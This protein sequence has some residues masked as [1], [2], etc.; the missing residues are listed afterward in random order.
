MANAY[1]VDGMSI[2]Q[3]NIRDITDRRQAEIKLE[4]SEM[5]YRQMFESGHFGIFTTDDKFRFIS[6]NPTICKLLGYTQIELMKMKFSDITYPGTLERDIQ[7]AKDLHDGKISIY[8]S[9]KRYIK[10]NKDVIWV[11]ITVSAIRD[12]Y[13]KFLYFLVIVEDIDE[14][15][16]H[17]GVVAALNKIE[18]ET[19]DRLQKS[20]AS[21]RAVLQSTADG[22][23]AVDINN[24]VLYANDRFVEIWEVPQ[25]ILKGAD[26]AKL[27]NY[28]VNQLVDPK[29]FIK[30]VKRL[31]KSKEESFDI[32]NFKNGKILER[33]SHPLLNGGVLTGRVWSFH[34]VTKQK[35]AEKSL[36]KSKDIFSLVFESSPYASAISKV[37]DGSLLSVNKAFEALTGVSKSEAIKSSSIKLN[38]WTDPKNRQYVVGQLKTN[39]IVDN[40]EF[41]FNTRMRGP[42]TGL[43]SARAL[44][45][46]GEPCILSSIADISAIKQAEQEVIDLNNRN[47]AILTSIGDAVFACDENGKVLLF[48]QAAERL[49]GIPATKIIGHRY[50]KVISFLKESDEKPVVDFVTEVINRNKIINNL[51]HTLILT[52]KGE[53]IPVVNTIAPIKKSSGDITGFVASF[54]DVTKERNIDKAKTE[55]V[56]LA[57]HQLRTPLTAINW[58]CEMLLSEDSGKLT[59]KQKKYTRETYRA[60]KKMGA[61]MDSLLNVSRLEVGTFVVETKPLKIIELAEKCLKELEPLKNK[62]KIVLKTNYDLD[63]KEFR[64]DVKLLTIV[65]QN[66]LSNAIKYTKPSGTVQL[67]IRQNKSDILITVNDTGVGIPV[68][69]QD[70]VFLKLFRADNARKI[71]P[72]GTGLGLYIVK[73][74]VDATGGNV[75]FTSKEGKGSTFS[76]SFPIEGMKERAGTKHLV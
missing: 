44:E 41:L 42:V 6:A 67:T 43:Y 28:V 9:E 8:Q 27:L 37:R 64:G 73:T 71:D 47:E 69:Q 13:A 63:L 14:L 61:L 68:D 24:K 30:E 23:L 32:L 52:A 74:I 35:Q 7:G 57:S 60:S 1:R 66:L 76:V 12:I 53:K 46:D 75:W 21:L 70:Q 40:E 38:L 34:D 56:S 10:K 16:K 48:N 33:V 20:E 11:R 36:Q 3:C 55:F 72:D 5:R 59:D 15:K 22:I 31:Y 49:T 26:D 4:E 29:L 17:E 62:R 18:Q 65:F 2:I 39:G 51:N 58:Y 19:K 50:D 45:I 25:S 54:R